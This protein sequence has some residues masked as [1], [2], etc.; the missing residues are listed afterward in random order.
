MFIKSYW[1]ND[2]NVSVII[3]L[4]NAEKYIAKALESCL[5]LTEVKEILVVDDGYKDNAKGIVKHY[6]E[7]YPVIKLFEHPNNENRGAGESRNVG[8][9][10]ATQEYIAFLDADDFYLPNRFQEDREVFEKYSDADGC[11][12]AIGSY[13]YSNKDREQF[14]RSS[15]SERTT[16]NHDTNPSP[17]NLFQGL[18]GM[19]SGYGYIHL[20]GLTLKRD[21]LFGTGVFFVDIKVHQDTDFLIKLAF[22]LKLYPSNL[23]EDTAVRG[24][25]SE[26]RITANEKLRVEEKSYKRYLMWQ[27]I[28]SWASDE[29]MPEKEYDYIKVRKD[30]YYLLS[31]S[32]RSPLALLK[33]MSENRNIFR[34]HLYG[35]LHRK[36]F[37]EGIYA[38]LIYKAL[39]FIIGQG[40]T[41]K[42]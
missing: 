11:Y 17:Q 23:V 4:Y 42:L 36:H 1:A 7:K 15:L 28:Y 31:L 30:C 26:N 41:K 5:A 13:F 21:S 38:R 12:N 34:S 32:S 20:N 9:R 10:N 35:S 24:V 27:S 39:N 3:P 25:H 6:Q 18:L 40:S 29:K 37:G 2:M 16:V 33:K 22:L 8:I 14:T 19:I